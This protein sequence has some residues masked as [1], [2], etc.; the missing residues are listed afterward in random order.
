MDGLFTDLF[1]H[2]VYPSLFHQ[3]PRYYYQGSGSIKSRVLHAARLRS[4]HAQ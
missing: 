3:D 1:S 2:A 4:H